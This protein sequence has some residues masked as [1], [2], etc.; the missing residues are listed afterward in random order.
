M[1]VVCVRIVVFGLGK[2]FVSVFVSYGV[3]DIWEIIIEDV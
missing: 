1:V 3:W 2:G